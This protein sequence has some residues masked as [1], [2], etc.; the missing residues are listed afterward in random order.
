[1]SLYWFDDGTQVP[2][3]RYAAESMTGQFMWE[4]W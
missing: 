4:L 2:N 1:M 3:T